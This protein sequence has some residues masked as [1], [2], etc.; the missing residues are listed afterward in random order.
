MEG[1]RANIS[2]ISNND[3]ALHRAVRIVA[4][5]NLAYFG[6]EFG[7]LWRLAPSHCDFARSG[8]SNTVDSLG[9]DCCSASTGSHPLVAGWRW[10]TGGK[11]VLRWPSRSFSYPQR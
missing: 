6:V 3:A 11:P 7:W 9:E 10:G 8:F 5:L 2:T 4:M 1:P